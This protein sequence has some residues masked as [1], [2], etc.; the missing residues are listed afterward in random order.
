MFLF[1][2]LRENFCTC[3]FIHYRSQSS[4]TKS[5]RQKGNRTYPLFS[6]FYSFISKIAEKPTT[7]ASSFV[8][9]IDDV[10]DPVP[11]DKSLDA[12]YIPLQFSNT[13]TTQ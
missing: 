2:I 8:F 13:N 5:S 3:F 10:T 6:Y 7:T 1:K 4:S 11:F 9:I 12:V